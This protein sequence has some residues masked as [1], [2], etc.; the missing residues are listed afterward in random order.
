MPDGIGLNTRF[1]DRQNTKYERKSDMI[2]EESKT[3]RIYVREAVT[4]DAARL[5]EIYAYYVESTAIT[6]DYEVPTLE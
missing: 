6:F 3:D 4:E 5:L 2:R 1:K